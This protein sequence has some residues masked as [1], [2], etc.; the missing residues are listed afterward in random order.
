[1][2]NFAVV[3]GV[4]FLFGMMF[5]IGKR[6]EY[7]KYM[8][9]TRGRAKV[10]ASESNKF[11]GR[12]AEELVN[13]ALIAE[14]LGNWHEAVERYIAAKYNNLSYTGIL[15]RVGKIYY[16][17]GDFTSADASFE[18]AIVFGENIDSANYYRG[19]IALGR[20]YGHG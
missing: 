18:R 3:I 19:M 8:I 6:Y 17:H 7:L 15:F 5:Y 9:V 16:D 4:L 11:P 1:M 2:Q 13:Q 10:A 20:L 14:R 12:S